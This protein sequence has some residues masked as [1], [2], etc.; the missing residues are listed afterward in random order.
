MCAAATVKDRS[1]ASGETGCLPSRIVTPGYFEALGV[2]IRGATPTW[3]ETDG[4]SAGV[5]VTQ[6]LAERLW[7]GEDA[8]GKG[9]RSSG[10]GD[11]FYRVVGVTAPLHEDG[12]DKPATEAVFY[13]MRPIPGTSLWSPPQS[14]TVV[15]RSRTMDAGALT[16]AIRQALLEIDPRVPLGNVETMERVVALSMARTSFT[17]LLLAIAASMALLLS[18]VGIFGVISYIVAQRRAEIGVRIAL[19]AQ[20]AQVSRLIVGQAMRLAA[21]GVAIGLVAA[22]ATSRVFQALLFEVSPTD[23]VVLAIVSIGLLGLAALASYGPASRS[24]RIDPAEVLRAD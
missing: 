13:P 2:S 6:T 22:V 5:V 8:L 21:I 20:P 19:G 12:L 11:A 3:S 14:M 15:V 1:P 4:L 7:P 23:P 16:S 17:M 18:A 9:I 24:A 10:R